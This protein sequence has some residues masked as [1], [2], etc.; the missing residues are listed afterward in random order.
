MDD[1][2]LLGRSEKDLTNNIT[3]AKTNTYDKNKIWIKE[4]C[5]Y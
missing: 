3:L 1:Q 2:N 5:L 4:M